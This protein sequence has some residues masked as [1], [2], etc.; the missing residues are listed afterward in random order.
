[1][2]KYGKIILALA[3]AALF[4]LQPC[5]SVL[6]E[7]DAE[8]PIVQ[9]KQVNLTVVDAASGTKYPKILDNKERTYVLFKHEHTLKLSSN[10]EFTGLYV[11]LEAPCNWTL[12][13]PDGTQMKFNK[14]DY[15]HKYVPL[16]QPVSG[17]ELSFPEG[18]M[19]T[20]VYA[21]TEGELPSW[22]QRWEQPCEKADL[23][24]LST[25][26]D[27]ELLWF[28]G[29][30]P[31]YAGELGYDVQ[32]VYLT[33]HS[34]TVR[35]HERLNGLWTVGVRHYPVIGPF[36]DLGATKKSLKAAS[37]R[38]G[39]DKVL[40]FQVETLR[41]FAPRVVLSQAINGEYG[42]GAH[43][44]NAKTALEA[45]EL[46]EDPANFPES[47]EKYG[48]CRVQKCYLHLWEENQIF[49]DWDSMKLE[50]FGGKTAW[51]MAIAGYDCHASQHQW[52]SMEK[53]ALKHD[54][55]RFGLAYTTVGADTEGLND[56]FEHVD[57]SD[58]L[59]PEEEEQ[60]PAEV[61]R[62]DAAVSPSDGTSAEAGGIPTAALIVAVMLLSTAMVAV[63]CVV[64]KKQLLQS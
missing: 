20:D 11:K 55:R 22:V 15:I 37:D 24:L 57:W 30:L 63:I 36:P 35:N 19:I 23:L 27:D 13:L 8:V 26:A 33:D 46:T 49:M 52:F 14:D 29:A 39:Y 1:M 12:T 9:A 41:R 21:F 31:Y 17:A 61:S 51:E 62:S 43:I 7:E 3:A 10:R 25:H 34:E 53:N 4:A 47:A 38:F 48:T 28:G 40:A 45:M 56:M 42:H 32:V 50:Q 54:C 64:Q 59:P 60:R 5:L 16:E 18:A 2:K 6:A 58:K 44:L